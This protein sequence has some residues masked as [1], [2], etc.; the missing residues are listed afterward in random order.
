MSYD[1]LSL[2]FGYNWMG[3]GL[4]QDLLFWDGC[5]PEAPVVREGKTEWL[6]GMFGVSS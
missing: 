2:I 5:S 1:P 3:T 6:G 4:C